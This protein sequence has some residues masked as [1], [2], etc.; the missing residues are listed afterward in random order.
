MEHQGRV[1]VE[2]WLSVYV[3]VLSLSSNACIYGSLGQGDIKEGLRDGS[4]VL[5]L[6][7]WSK[8]QGK[9]KVSFHRIPDSSNVTDKGVKNDIES[10]ALTMTVNRLVLEWEEKIKLHLEKEMQFNQWRSKHFKGMHPTL[11]A[12]KL[13]SSVQLLFD[14][15]LTPPPSVD[16]PAPKV[17][18]LIAEVVAPELAASTG[19]PSS[20]TVDQ[21]APSLSNS[22]TT[23]KT[24]SPVIPNDVEEG[25]HDLDV[26]HMNTDL[27][28]GILIPENNSEA[29][30][31]SDVIPT[32]MHTAAPNSEHVT[33][34]TTD[35]PLDNIIS[36]LER[37]RFHKT[38]TP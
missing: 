27:F 13:R 23:P 2:F 1:F 33:K 6:G 29:S 37:P 19:L 35:H 20:T 7:L 18:A 24:Q 17:I 3:Y 8:R 4:M 32:V 11:I 30:S 28:F 21:D 25:N 5:G 10:I 26:T 36:E 16:R 9:H 38:P 31:S 12:T 34:W 14:E 22:Q 15:L